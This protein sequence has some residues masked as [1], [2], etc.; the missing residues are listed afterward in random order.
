[1]AMY[2]NVVGAPLPAPE[3]E[4]ATRYVGFQPG[5]VF[6]EYF[7]LDTLETISGKC[8][9][10]LEG[11]HPEGKR[12]VVDHD[13]L[14][15]V[16]DAIFDQARGPIFEMMDNVIGTVVSRIRNEFETIEQNG[17]LTRWVLKYDE[18]PRFGLRMHEPIYAR[19][20]RDIN[21]G[22]FMMNY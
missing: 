2:G 3:P 22:G 21:K 16:R 20:L 10:Y 12:I 4:Y 11:V 5:P 6:E 19:K 13:V 18:D 15:H 9:E 14:R 17:K 1:M 8:T 7:T